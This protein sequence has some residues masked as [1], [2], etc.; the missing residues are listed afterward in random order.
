[1]GEEG[2]QREKVPSFAMGKPKGDFGANKKN[3]TKKNLRGKGKSL[4]KK[5]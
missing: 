1:M 2:G 4:L 3:F 5:T